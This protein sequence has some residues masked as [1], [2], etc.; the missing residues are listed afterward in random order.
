[1]GLRGRIVKAVPNMDMYYL[2]TNRCSI[3]L[4]IGVKNLMV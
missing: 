2:I 4:S 3:D 1:M